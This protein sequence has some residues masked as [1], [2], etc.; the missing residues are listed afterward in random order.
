MDRPKGGR[1]PQVSRAGR[2]RRKTILK[3]SN[4]G[5]TTKQV[6]GIIIQES[7]AR[8]HHNYIYPHTLQVGLQAEGARKGHVNTASAEEKNDFKK[9]PVNTCGYAIPKKGF[10]LYLETNPSFFMIPW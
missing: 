1:H 6:E 9:R 8:Y 5:W 3:E 2:S 7:G 10:T 4:H